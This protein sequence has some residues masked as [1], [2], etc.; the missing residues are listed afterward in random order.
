[1][2]DLFWLPCFN[3]NIMIYTL[4]IA[5]DEKIG[6]LILRVDER[7]KQFGQAEAPAYKPLLFIANGDGFDVKRPEQS[8]K[9][10]ETIAYMID[11]RAGML[12][13]WLG[14][15][16][17]KQ[18]HDADEITDF[19]EE[20]YIHNVT[21]DSPFEPELHIVLYV[22]L[23]VSDTVAEIEQIIKNLPISY[24][25][26]VNVVAL[27]YDVAE[28]TGLLKSK[29][30]RNERNKLMRKSMKELQ[31]LHNIYT[32][33]KY[34]IFFQNRNINGWSI[35]YNYEKLICT[36]SDIAIN[37]TAN[38]H[39][40]AKYVED[41]KFVLVVNSQSYVLDIYYAFNKWLGE[42]FANETKDFIIDGDSE[43]ES[44]EKAEAIFREITK[45]E[46]QVVKDFILSLKLRDYEYSIEE[47]EKAFKENCAEKIKQIIEEEC[48]D[49]PITVR[50]QLY[51]KFHN[52]GG[53]SFDETEEAIAEA[54]EQDRLFI[55]NLAVGEDIKTAYEQ[56]EAFLKD[57]K[58]LKLQIENNEAEIE[59]LKDQL[60]DADYQY[61]EIN[62][63]GA[64]FGQNIFKPNRVQNRPLAE[65]Y[66]PDKNETLPAAVDLR[67]LF[68]VV[69]NQGHQGACTAFSL[70]SVFEYF[71]MRFSEGKY[72]DLSEAFSYFNSRREAG[73]TEIDEGATFN[74]VLKAAKDYG[75]CLENL[76]PYN[77]DTYNEI[78]SDESYQDGISRCVTEAKNIQIDINHIKSAIA[79]G[80]PVVVSIKSFGAM[81]KMANGFVCYDVV[82]N[83]VQTDS[84]HAMV[85]CGYSDKEGYFIIRNSWGKD[86]GDNGYC[87]YPYAA[88]R[89]KN[90][91]DSCYV[92]TGISNSV[93]DSMGENLGKVHSLD[94]DTTTAKYEIL[95]NMLVEKNHELQENKN[96]LSKIRAQY[97]KLCRQLG[98]RDVAEH[99]IV[100]INQQIAEIRNKINGN[101]ST[102]NKLFKRKNEEDNELQRL[103]FERNSILLNTIIINGLLQL[104]REY[105]SQAGVIERTS[106]LLSDENESIVSRLDDEKKS[107]F[108]KI[109]PQSFNLDTLL[110]AAISQDSIK[111]LFENAKKAISDVYN[112]KIGFY[113]SFG[114]LSRGLSEYVLKNLNV[115]ILDY[116]QDE[117]GK[118]FFNSINSSS[119]MAMVEGWVPQGSGNEV[120][121]LSMPT[122]DPRL[123]V[124]LCDSVNMLVSTDKYRVTFLHV[125]RYMVNELSLFAVVEQMVGKAQLLA[126]RSKLS[127]SDWLNT[128]DSER[129]FLEIQPQL[130][131]EELEEVQ[132]KLGEIVEKEKN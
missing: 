43:D 105:L 49:E 48:S 36:C 101:N 24:K 129:F 52:V 103:I 39:D 45:R 51:K 86:F 35:N 14:K 38:Y 3:H 73:N 12:L 130:T 27:P 118:Q 121:Y 47:L 62:D 54:L 26:V 10:A 63:E 76:C 119:V 114:A 102:F 111:T 109:T 75:L 71:L 131:Q 124:K 88:F 97:S 28:V 95:R 34:V 80:L 7:I 116:L 67:P 78:P 18:L 46:N 60:S 87:Y 125:E 4:H 91:I 84:Y 44:E 5:F 112:N 40:V 126:S 70:V 82:D 115:T 11:W 79:K 68:P 50:H 21:V 104:N 66:A 64:K 117:R 20:E 22:P 37:L 58:K 19:F 32:S 89:D 41:N 81:R 85:I 123:P 122:E 72:T 74:D 17:T 127:M 42:L 56:L 113:E 106:D 99:D 29:Q 65:T 98:E 110:G 107:Y 57:I 23:Y 59:S 128:K 69:K 6:E 13:E 92:I 132:T 90:S 8:H 53:L 55:E 93:L 30:E 120:I 25:I 1:M 108:R 61:V 100:E 94:G 96:Q 15:N 2:T 33:F 16:P 9:K 31:R 77:E 83:T